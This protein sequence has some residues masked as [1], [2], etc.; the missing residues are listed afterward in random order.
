MTERALLV[1][2]PESGKTT[3]LAAL[4]HIIASG[5]V[6]ESLVLG[7]AGPSM[8]HLNAAPLSLVAG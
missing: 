1:G 6:N 3:F 5:D 8:E 2:L 4:W 7:A